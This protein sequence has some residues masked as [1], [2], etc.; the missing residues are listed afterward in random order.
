MKKRIKN[1][2]SSEW[3]QISIAF[4]ITL[5]LI[6]T[7]INVNEQIKFNESMMRPWIAPSISGDV[8][9]TDSNLRYKIILSNPG[10]S[11]ALDIYLYS[12]LDTNKEFP[13]EI[14]KEEI[15]DVEKYSKAIVFPDQNKLMYDYS[16]SA[17][18]QVDQVEYFRSADLIINTLLNDKFY[19]HLYV[20]YKSPEERTYYLK[21]TFQMKYLKDV[22]NGILVDWSYIWNSTEKL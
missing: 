4:V 13:V 18:F 14:I 19:V 5:T 3:I 7:S 2:T 9:I 15:G 16:V 20:I 8:F 11:P 21:E 10:H 6:A 17:N 12:R 22:D 1:I